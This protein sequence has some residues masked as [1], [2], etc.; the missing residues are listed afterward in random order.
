MNGM[1][2]WTNESFQFFEGNLN[3]PTFQAFERGVG[4]GVGGGS[5]HCTALPA[6]LPNQL[7]VVTAARWQIGWRDAS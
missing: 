4:G 1:N 6:G 3:F 5:S 2:P 7:I